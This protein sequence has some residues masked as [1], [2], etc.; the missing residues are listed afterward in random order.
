MEQLVN[1]LMDKLKSHDLKLEQSTST[2]PVLLSWRSL[3][4]DPNRMVIVYYQG[5]ECSYRSAAFARLCLRTM[6]EKGLSVV[7][8]LTPRLFDGDEDIDFFDFLYSVRE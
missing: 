7:A 6:L 8:A 3:S 5:C 2:D 4:D 1:D